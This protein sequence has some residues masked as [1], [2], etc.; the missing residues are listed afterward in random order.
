MCKQHTQGQ[1]LRSCSECSGILDMVKPEVAKGWLAREEP[2]IGDAVSRYAVRSDDPTPTL[3]LPEEIVAFHE[4]IAF[5]GYDQET[6]TST[7]GST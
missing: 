3:I 7:F 5:H 1:M 2:V 4:I 6:H